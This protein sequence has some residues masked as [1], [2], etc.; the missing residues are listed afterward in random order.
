MKAMLDELTMFRMESIIYITRKKAAA[1]PPLFSRPFK[2]LVGL[3]P[4]CLFYSLR[5]GSLGLIQVF[6]FI[7]LFTKV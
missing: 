3:C 1:K 6:P 5:H 2:Q 4:T 7:L